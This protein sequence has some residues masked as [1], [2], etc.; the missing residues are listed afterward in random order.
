MNQRGFISSIWVYLIVGAL[1]VGLG[2]G[3]Y[4]QTIKVGELNTKIDEQ[5][6]ALAE[7]ERLRKAGEKAQVLA[8]SLKAKA[9]AE[10]VRTH[11]ALVNL[12]K[13]H[14]KLL[15]LVLPDGLTVGLLNAIDEANS[16]LPARKLDGSDETTIP[17]INLGGLYEWATE[18]VPQAIK[19]CNADKLAIRSLCKQGI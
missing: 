9:E 4:S 7:A 10:A 16:D 5:K 3:F 2:Y 12:R 17:K 19:Q 15:S 13:E 6:E 18:V 14:E 1:I 8:Q 11:L